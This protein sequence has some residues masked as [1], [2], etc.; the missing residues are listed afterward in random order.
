[1]V[2][3]QR[4]LRTSINLWF[5][6]DGDVVS[7]HTLAFAAYEIFH[8]IS[9]HRNPY[10]RDLIFDTFLIK[11][12][13]RSDWNKLVRRDANFFKH[14]DRDPEATLNFDPEFSEWF[15]LYASVAR[16]LCGMEQISEESL[17]L[18][19]FQ[20]NRPDFLTDAGRTFVAERIPAANLASIRQL[21]RSQFR[22]GW[23]LAKLSGKTPIVEL[24]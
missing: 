24:S 2:A 20:I 6:D 9:E 18:W 22:K 19:W 10:R 21:T 11:D 5:D 17:F 4:Q 8:A 13:F 3:A 15:I 1:M 12:E 16:Q 23:Q 14:G 7:I